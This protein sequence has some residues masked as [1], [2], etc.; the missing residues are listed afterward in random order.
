LRELATPVCLSCL[1]EVT[2]DTH[3][4]ETENG[5]VIGIAVSILQLQN[6]CKGYNL[7]LNH[8]CSCE[9]W[10]NGGE[11]LLQNRINNNCVLGLRYSED[12]D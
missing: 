3:A 4:R 10:W 2:V 8:D 9:K 5:S 1:L 7:R 12:P 6:M 11:N